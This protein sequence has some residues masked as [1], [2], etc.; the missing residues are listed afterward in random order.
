M[1]VEM[2]VMDGYTATRTIREWEARQGATRIPILALSAHAMGAAFEKSVEA[3]CDAHLTKPI[4]KPTLLR[5]IA[6][7]CKARGAICV[8][9][10]QEVEELVPWYLDTMRS[11]I[12]TLAAALRAGDY[13]AIR[14]MGHNMK[15]A[16]AG[17][18][19]DAITKIGASL[20][21]AAEE[22]SDGLIETGIL[23]LG[24]YLDRVKVVSNSGS[25]PS[26]TRL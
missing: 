17:Y 22:E 25:R 12:A 14:V 7:H 16:G 20:E 8:R 6:E 3:G 23:A 15:G 5:A 13:D 11:N 18:G 26:I 19:F 10:S 2:P 1:D 4:L 21:A 9:P 24:D